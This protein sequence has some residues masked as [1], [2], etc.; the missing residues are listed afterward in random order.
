MEEISVL[1]LQRRHE[2]LEKAD[3]EGSNIIVITKSGKKYLIKERFPEIITLA[4]EHPLP[5]LIVRLLPSKK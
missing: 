5:G 3:Y 4:K 2:S 1:E